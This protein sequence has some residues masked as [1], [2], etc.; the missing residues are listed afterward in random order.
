MDRDSLP[1]ELR[2]F[3]DDAGRLSRWPSRQK[4]QRAA[5]AYL[6]GKFTPGR[7]YTER[8]ANFL[9]MDW[10][11]FGDWAMLRRALYDWKFLD[12]ESDGTRYRLRPAT[13]ATADESG[14]PAP[15]S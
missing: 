1:R 12:R 10:H 7:E 9:L 15:G 8:E 6:A 2:P 11:S 4:V 14:A 5:I 13:P 3:V